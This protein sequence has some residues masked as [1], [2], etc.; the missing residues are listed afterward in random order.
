MT[1]GVSSKFT[2]SATSTLAL[3]IAVV[4]IASVASASF[5]D[6]LKRAAKDNGLIQARDTQAKIDPVL[7]KLGK[8][9]FETKALS[10]NG[11][12]SCQSC[13]LKKFG[14]ADGIPN[15]VGIGGTGE[16]PARVKSG[17]AIIPRKTLPLWGRGGIGFKV[18]FWDGKVDFSES[19]KVSQFGINPP[20]SDA[21]V[22]AVHRPVVEIREMLID[23]KFVG[24]NKKEKLKSAKRIYAAIVDRVARQEQHAIKALA[25]HLSLPQEKIEFVHL[26]R[27]IA[28]FIREEF[29]VRQTKFHK[30]VFRN[31]ALSK[32]ELE[33][34]IL[35]YGKGKCSVCHSGPYF[36][37]FK[38]HSI[39]TPQ[40]G[41]GKNG[42]GVDYGRYNVTHNPKDLYQFRTPPLINVAQTAP[43]GHSGSLR[44]LRDAIVAHFDPLRL[45]N[46]KRMKPLDRHEFYKRL[47]LSSKNIV[48]IGHL[49]KD[50]VNNLIAFL[51]SISY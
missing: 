43:Y 6:I 25:A 31:G 11:N 10:L 28:E 9:F 4:T 8:I 22:T 20:S 14:S 48:L 41:F 39:A 19:N 15:A 16:G 34:A 30:F 47:S 24:S 12:I 46:L 5:E 2:R 35:F 42:F 38:F 36:S 17:G 37:D 32:S 27:G 1:C 3:V 13:H 50:E 44:T 18:L 49:D 7:A 26:A 23:D 51:K 40:I 33:G 21:L 29:P 45:V